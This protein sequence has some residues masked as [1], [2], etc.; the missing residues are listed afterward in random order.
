MGALQV[1]TV[2]FRQMFQS[3]AALAA[4]NLALRQQVAVLQRS[5]KRPRL[6]RSR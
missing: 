4:E 1:A 2:V 6:H 5:V 3:R